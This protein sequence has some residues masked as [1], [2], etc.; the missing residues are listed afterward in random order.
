[1]DLHKHLKEEWSKMEKE[2]LVE[3]QGVPKGVSPDKHERCVKAVKKDSSVDN[4]YAV[5]NASL[6]KESSMGELDF[7]LD[8]IAEKMQLLSNGNEEALNYIM[9]ELHKKL[10]MD[11]GIT[12]EGGGGGT[13]MGGGAI[14]L[15]KGRVGGTTRRVGYMEEELNAIKDSLTEEELQKLEEYGALTSWV[16]ALIDKSRARQGLNK[17]VDP[18]DIGGDAGRTDKNYKGATFGG[19]D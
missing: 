8:D 13:G 2:L 9:S 16:G 6:T 14:A 1:M 12:E 17:A 5:C 3:K 7:E 19:D 4:P 15:H 18:L 10:G 11:E